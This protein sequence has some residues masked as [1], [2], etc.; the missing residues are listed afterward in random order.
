MHW[1]RTALRWI[2]A[3]GLLCGSAMAVQAIETGAP[4][5]PYEVRL[6]DGALF[7]PSQAVGKVVMLH[8]WASWCVPCRAEMPAMEQY[9]RQHHGEG[10]ELIAITVDD[11]ADMEKARVI[12]RQFSF[13]AA[14]IQDA[15]VKGYGRI[16]RIPLTFVIDRQGRLRL[17]AW[18]GDASG[19]TATALDQ[20][21]TPLLNER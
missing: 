13:P 9:Y 8:F 19:I 1:N 17:D 18:D 3:G 2:L 7:T 14:S 20:A 16:W 21:I 6:L 10:L 11:A 5:P 15:K 4:A 12:M